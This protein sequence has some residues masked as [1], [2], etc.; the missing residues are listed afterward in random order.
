[1]DHYNGPEIPKTTMW[2]V[3]LCFV[4]VTA[5]VVYNLCCG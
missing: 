2:L 4:L 5:V 3:V 1:M